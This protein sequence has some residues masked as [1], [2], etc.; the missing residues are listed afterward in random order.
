M[1][2]DPQLQPCLSCHERLPRS[3]GLCNRGHLR[4]GRAVRSGAQTWAELEA[5]GL[6]LPAAPAGTAWRKGFRVG[7]AEGE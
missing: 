7:T 1:P 4:L 2:A 5:A 3:R 6:A